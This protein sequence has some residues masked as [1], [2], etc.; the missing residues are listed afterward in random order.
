M[1]EQFASILYEKGKLKKLF[2]HPEFSFSFKGLT[3][4]IDGDNKISNIT[5]LIETILAYLKKKK[6][7]VLITRVPIEII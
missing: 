4:S 5:S 1:Y 2:L 6:K 7:R 3:F